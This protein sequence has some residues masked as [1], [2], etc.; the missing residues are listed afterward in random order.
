MWASHACHVN[1]QHTVC[2]IARS[3]GILRSLS[4]FFIRAGARGMLKLSLKWPCMAVLSPKVDLHTR[5]SCLCTPLTLGLYTITCTSFSVNSCRQHVSNAL[6]SFLLN[7]R[8]IH[9]TGT[10]HYAIL[11]CWQTAMAQFVLT[12]YRIELCMAGQYHQAC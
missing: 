2:S 11:A 10:P 4:C 1:K 6:L 8:S 7:L 5:E 3:S 9:G 12:L